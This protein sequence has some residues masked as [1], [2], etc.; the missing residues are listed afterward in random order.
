VAG[1]SRVTFSERNDAR[2][3]YF[4][5]AISLALLMMDQFALRVLTSPFRGLYI[6]ATVTAG[7]SGVLGMNCFLGCIW[8]PIPKALR[9]DG[10]LTALHLGATPPAE[11]GQTS[12]QMFSSLD[13][14]IASNDEELVDSSE[15]ELRDPIQWLKL[16]TVVACVGA[17]FTLII[18]LSH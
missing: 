16:V 17:N 18:L 2:P 8:H 11:E 7:L 3:T 14:N 12:P 15:V 4:V 6:V 10:Q 9:A 5:A 1:I 13:D